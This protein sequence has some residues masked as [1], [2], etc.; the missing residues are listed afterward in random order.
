MKTLNIWL[1][2]GMALSLI[3]TTAVIYLPGISDAFGFEHISLAEYGVALG[4]AFLVLPIVEI[5]KFIQR[6][7]SRN[8]N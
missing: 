7:F 6:S 1:L 5:V 3:L 4:L 2:A 8:K